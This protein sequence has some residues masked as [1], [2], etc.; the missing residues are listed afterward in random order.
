VSYQLSSKKVTKK[1]S[2]L[3][4]GANERTKENIHLLQGLPLYGEDVIDFGQRPPSLKV[5]A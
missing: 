4:F 2:V 5:L 3:S 1:V